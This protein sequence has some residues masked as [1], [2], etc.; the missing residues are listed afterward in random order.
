MQFNADLAQKDA[1]D[2]ID[3]VIVD[4]LHASHVV[5]GSDFHFGRDRGGHVGTLK[6]DGRFAVDGVALEMLGDDPVSSTRI[7][8]AL[9]AGD[10]AAAN[11]MLGWEWEIE[12]IVG[13][14]DK[15]GRDLGYPTANIALGETI[16]PAYGIYAARAH[17]GD[18]WRNG[19]A[20]IGIRPMFKL[21]K[22]LLEVHV[23]DFTGDL[24]GQSLR[25]RPIRKLR[26]EAAFAGPEALKATIAKDCADARNILR[27][28][29]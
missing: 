26:D 1:A 25:V 20:N 29:A 8:E 24:Y 4:H 10:I 11:A 27:S 7:R 18:E 19:V 15:K 14:G 13:H 6:S 28:G 17:I 21:E 16:V 3:D 12:G 22:P 2:F 23:F 9:T 5:V